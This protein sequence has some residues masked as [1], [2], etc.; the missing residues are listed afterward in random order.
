M[1]GTPQLATLGG[2]TVLDLTQQLPGPYATLL[3]AALGARVIKIEPPAGDIG[4]T[5]DAAMFDNVNAGK[6]SVVLDLKTERGR[7]ALLRLAR[8]SDAFVEGFRPGVAGRLGAG[9]DDIAGVRSDIVYCSLS[10]FGA[11][12]PYRTVPGHD[13]NYLGVAGGVRREAADVS[14]PSRIG[15]PAV[16]MASGTMAC[17]SVLAAL[18]RRHHSG[19]GAYLDVAMLD[20]AVYWA[21]VKPPEQEDELSEPAY[22]ALRCADGSA[23][24]IAVLEDKFWGN[25]CRTLGWD[26]WAADAGLATHEQRRRRAA[27]IDARLEVAFAARPRAEWLR[28]LWDADVPVA[29]VHAPGQVAADPQVATRRLFRSESARPADGGLAPPLPIAL[30]ADVPARAPVLGADTE[31]VLAE[32]GMAG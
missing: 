24:T 29:P 30:R 25:L 18:L 3:L 1:T 12:G 2:V 20:S 19:E 5:L 10:G 8:V 9:Y 21:G 13:L 26:D 17:L 16:D 14:G 32:V 27:E 6:L 7:G 23:L 28:I 31:D 11:E 4:R 22:R 15:I